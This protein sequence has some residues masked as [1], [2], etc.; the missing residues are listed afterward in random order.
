METNSKRKDRKVI[1]FYYPLMFESELDPTIQTATAEVTIQIQREHE[2]NQKDILNDFHLFFQSQLLSL[3]ALQQFIEAQMKALN[4]PFIVLQV[5]FYWFYSQNEIEMY[6]QSLVTYHVQYE[7]KSQQ[8]QFKIILASPLS[9]LCPNFLTLKEPSPLS[10]DILQLAV[11][12]VDPSQSWKEKLLN[13]VTTSASQT[14]SST[15]EFIENVHKKLHNDKS[16]K[17]SHI[18]L[19]A[20]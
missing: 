18:C 6:E 14:T 12:V 15:Q 11:T 8:Y 3:E 9:S 7:Q 17:A 10:T 19:K 16:Y 2:L 5:S 20:D 1:H 4:P 13:L